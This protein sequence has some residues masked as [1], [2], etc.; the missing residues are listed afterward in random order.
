MTATKVASSSLELLESL[1]YSGNS[2]RPLFDLGSFEFPLHIGVSAFFI[3][4]KFFCKFVKY[5]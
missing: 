2:A 3:F 4:E 1:T 5:Y